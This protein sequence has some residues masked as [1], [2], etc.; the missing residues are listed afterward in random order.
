[1]LLP[2]SR[3]LATVQAREPCK[4]HRV[5][6]MPAVGKEGPG[7]GATAAHARPGP[8]TEESRQDDDA[9]TVV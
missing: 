7:I 4:N 6:L 8:W 5:S 2:A 3:V 1:M 9:G